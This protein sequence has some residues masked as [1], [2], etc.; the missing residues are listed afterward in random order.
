MPV[1]SWFGDRFLD[2]KV[3]FKTPEPSVWVLKELIAEGEYIDAEFEED[4]DVEESEEWEEDGSPEFNSVAKAVYV[5]ARVDGDVITEEEAIIKV[6]MQYV[7]ILASSVSTLLP[8]LTPYDDTLEYTELIR[9]HVFRVP[10][11]ETE[12][13]RPSE[14]AKQATEVPHPVTESELYALQHLTRAECSSTPTLRSWKQTKQGKRGWVPGGYVVYLLMNKLPGIQIDQIE[15]LSLKERNEL[16]AA[17]KKAWIEC[18]DCGFVSL[19][20]TFKNLLWDRESQKCYIVDF[21]IWDP[22]DYSPWKDG[23]YDLWCLT[24]FCGN[25]VHRP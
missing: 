20:T 23:I 21:E 10:H 16:R 25:G 3:S 19:D 18:R 5:C 6:H 9:E 24:V 13:Q 17:F 2:R 15:E 1:L 4:S 22:G 11:Y 14:R 7:S 12:S 8:G